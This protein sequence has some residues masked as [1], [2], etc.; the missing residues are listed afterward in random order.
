VEVS[1]MEDFE[2]RLGGPVAANETTAP[3][4]E[5]MAFGILTTVQS[6]TAA[7]QAVE[8]WVIPALTRIG[9]LPTA[10]A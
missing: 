3:D 6:C 7:V 9:V 8:R 4:L 1:V 2:R 5:D 10:S